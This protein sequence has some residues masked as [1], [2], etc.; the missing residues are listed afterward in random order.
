MRT[1]RTAEDRFDRTLIAPM[2]LGSVLNPINSSI[3]AIS[4]IPIGRDLGAAPSATA[5]LISALYLA[6]SVGQPVVGRLVDLFGPRRWYLLGA[7]LV[8]IAGLMGWLAP[9]LGWLIAAR[10]VLGIGT[11]AGYP[12]AMALVRSESGR[13]GR[14]VSG[15]MLTVLTVSSQ[16]VNVIGPALGGALIGLGGWR[17]T[18]TV[19]IPLALACL[20]LGAL[21]LPKDKDKD[22]AGKGARPD[23]GGSAAAVGSPRLWSVFDVPGIALFAAGLVSLLLWAMTPR[24]ATLWFVPLAAILLA[25]FVLR[26]LHTPSPFVDVRALRGNVPLVLT[27]VRQALG[28]IVAYA[29]LYAFSQWMQEGRGLDSLTAGLL[30]LPI[31][32]SAMVVSVTTGRSPALRAKL[33]VGAAAQIGAS[34]LLLWV[35]ADSPLVLLAIIALVVGIPQGLLNLA[36]Q[37]AMYHQV[38]PE[39]TA[40]S[41]GLLRTFMYLG[42]IAAATANGLLLG[43]R[44]DSDGIHAVGLFTLVVAAVLLLLIL[45]DRSLRGPRAARGRRHAPRAAVVHPNP[46][47]PDPGRGTT[48]TQED[49]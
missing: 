3:I 48:G 29:L 9:G 2:I 12:A 26:E 47:A 4:L 31:F 25:A 43:D 42:A 13:T 11:C 5:W 45:L 33:L 40:S 35:H 46:S 8:G 37:A 6:T 23:G 17:A 14:D 21:F 19:N 34:I 36:N 24:V 49:S 18:F 7:A 28:G 30:L 27:F 38:D 15:G 39:R 10:V 41:A 20:V 44:A 16:T 1:A 22:G 32:A